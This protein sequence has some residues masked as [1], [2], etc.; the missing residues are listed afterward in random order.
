MTAK[1]QVEVLGGRNFPS[2]FLSFGASPY[3]EMTWNTRLFKGKHKT[4]TSNPTWNETFCIEDWTPESFDIPFAF[5]VHDNKCFC[6]IGV[7]KMGELSVTL[8]RLTPEV[9]EDKWYPLEKNNGEVHVKFLLIGNPYPPPPPPPPRIIQYVMQPPPQQQVVVVMKA[10]PAPPPPQ[11]II[12]VK[13]SPQPVAPSS[14]QVVVQSSP[15]PVVASAPQP[16]APSAPQ[17]VA[18]S[19]PQ[20]AE[21]PPVY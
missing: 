11:Q 9:P 3:V 5:E 8:P 14:P 1:L 15:Q 16:V 12:V 18:P 20:A 4:R 21:V 13:S 2:V 19:A 6:C 7:G 10:A 17:L